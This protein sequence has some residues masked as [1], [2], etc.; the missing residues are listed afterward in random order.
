MREIPG[1]LEQIFKTICEEN[2]LVVLPKDQKKTAQGPLYFLELEINEEWI[3]LLYVDRVA[4]ADFYDCNTD[5]NY[6][7]YSVLSVYE[8]GQNSFLQ[9]QGLDIA[10]SLSEKLNDEENQVHRNIIKIDLDNF[11]EVEELLNAHIENY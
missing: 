11:S 4:T 10:K 2:N 8:S 6:L 1:Q 9:D 7:N 3:R 5:Q